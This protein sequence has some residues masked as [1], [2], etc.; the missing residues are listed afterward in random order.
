MRKV[1]VGDFRITDEEKRAILEV[2]DQGRLSEGK[3]V[4]QFEDTFARYIGTRYAVALSS[5]TAAIMVGLSALLHHNNY[6]IKRGS[7]VITSPLTYIAT[8]NAI[9]QTGFEPVFVDIDPETFHITPDNV[10]GLLKKHQSRDEFSILL[11]VHLMGY[12]CEMDRM[13]EIAKRYNLVVAEDSAQAHG[14]IYQGKKTGS[15][16]SFGAFSFYIA[17]NIQAGEMGAVTT[18]DPDIKKLVMKIKANGRLCDCP[19]C[20][21]SKGYCPREPTDEDDR[22]PRFTH[23]II[24]YNFKTMEFQA[25]LGI[26][27]MNKA[28]WIFSR[29]QE[30][31][32]Y[33]N[34]KLK[35]YEDIVKLPPFDERVSYLA[36]PLVLKPEAPITRYRLR[37]ELEHFGVET[38]PLFGSIPTQQPAYSFLREEYKGK[39][40]NADFIGEHGF[41][42]GCHQYLT[43]EDLDYIAEAFEK[44]LG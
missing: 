25:A 7:K 10:E 20:T 21:R 16:S 44:I 3:K 28:D 30:N 11:P 18:D 27:Q 15:W 31:V 36:Y 23:D 12:P 6:R 22:D 19:V 9:V 17:H 35:K 32:L 5:G 29:R 39:L 4:A 24:G 41:Y 13:N 1:A 38:R 42:I 33:L 2:L 43:K 26:T 14:S 8:V 37:H 34:R 40:K